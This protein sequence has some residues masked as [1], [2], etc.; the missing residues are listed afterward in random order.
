MNYTYLVESGKYKKE[1]LSPIQQSYVSGM[2]NVLE[3][4]DEFE[5]IAA[6]QLELDEDR[7]L[8]RIFLEHWEDL[9]AIFERFMKSEICEAI[10]LMADLN[11]KE[12]FQAEEA[13]TAEGIGPY[14]E[15]GGA[16]A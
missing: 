12:K 15:N 8:D 13:R 9:R 16:R 2:E 4:L 5:S 10:V 1:M 14:G 11:A 6:D 7:T 3:T